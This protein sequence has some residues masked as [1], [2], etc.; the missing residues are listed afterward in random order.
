MNFGE[1]LKVVTPATIGAIL[2]YVAKTLLDHVLQTR[3]IK[4]EK[5]ADYL[6]N[7]SKHDKERHI[8]TSEHLLIPLSMSLE[9][10]SSRLEIWF[11]GKW[12]HSGYTDHYAVMTT[13]YEFCCAC[14]WLDRE[15]HDPYLAKKIDHNVTEELRKILSKISELPIYEQKLIAEEMAQNDPSRFGPIS[16]GAFVK[17][18]QKS[19]AIGGLFKIIQTR[20]P[21]KQKGLPGEDILCEAIPRIRHLALILDKYAH[22]GYLV[23]YIIP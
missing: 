23:D 4:S 22:E 1:L 10:L 2:G 8:Y 3:R 9:K 21:D 17:K 20:D 15:N 16:Y 13:C 18:E 11:S 7:N 19:N 12:R 5:L 14:Y 6:L